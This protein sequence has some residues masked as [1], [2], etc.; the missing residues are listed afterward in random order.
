MVSNTKM[1]MLAELAPA[2]ALEALLASHI[3]AVNELLRTSSKRLLRA[4][5]QTADPNELKQYLSLNR[6]ILKQ[7]EA[8]KKLKNKEQKI[9]VH[10]LNVNDGG[11]AVVGVVGQGGV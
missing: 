4:D 7:L 2:N 11:Q 9:V 10:H 3:M 6:L 5:V 1:G 8:M